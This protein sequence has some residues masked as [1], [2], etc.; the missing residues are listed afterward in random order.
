MPK[1]KA[2]AVDHI[3]AEDDSQPGQRFFL[4]HWAGYTADFDSWEPLKNLLPGAKELLREWD[5]KR[6]QETKERKTAAHDEKREF[7]APVREK[8][9]LKRNASQISLH[10]QGKTNA[11]SRVKL[12][13]MV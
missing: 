1:D 13:Q 4:I 9:G 11:S 12:D 2:W 8:K 7:M 10:N 3:I 6:K 5:K